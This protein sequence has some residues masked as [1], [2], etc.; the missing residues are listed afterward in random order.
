LRA[1]TLSVFYVHRARGG[2]GFSALHAFANAGVGAK[3]PRR[4]QRG[5]S[6]PPQRGHPVIPTRINHPGPVGGD[7][8][9]K[10]KKGT[11]RGL[12]RPQKKIEVRLFVATQKRMGPARLHSPKKGKT[13]ALS[14]SKWASLHSG[15]RVFLNRPG[16]G[17]SPFRRGGPGRMRA[18]FEL[19]P[20]WPGAPANNP[21]TR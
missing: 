4:F 10:K 8:G 6:A 15:F 3:G 2:E 9:K 17:A 18:F 12:L 13:R 20:T 19:G 21:P 7:G 14:K 5:G 1:Q 16:G 11:A